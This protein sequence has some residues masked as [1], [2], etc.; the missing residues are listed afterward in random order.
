MNMENVTEIVELLIVGMMTIAG[1]Y[2]R[3]L[4][5][6]E[7]RPLSDRVARLEQVGAP[8][9][10]QIPTPSQAHEVGT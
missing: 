1:P 4:I 8:N 5:R 2:L 7:I 9:R 10:E 6:A 3:R